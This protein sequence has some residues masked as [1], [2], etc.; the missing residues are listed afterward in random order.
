MV[1]KYECRTNFFFSNKC[2]ST[3]MLHEEQSTDNKSYKH[4]NETNILI[5]HLIWYMWAWSSCLSNLYEFPTTWW[6]SITVI[7]W[8]ST[9]VPS[10]THIRPVRWL[11]WRREIYNISTWT[12]DPTGRRVAWR[13]IDWYQ[14]RREFAGITVVTIGVAAI[15]RRGMPLLSLRWTDHRWCVMWRMLRVKEGSWMRR[16]GK[17]LVVG[18]IRKT[19]QMQGTLRHILHTAQSRRR[20][21]CT[22]WPAMMKLAQVWVH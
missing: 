19:H 4:G 9:T 13:S 16:R 22:R 2:I 8:S 18:R 6:W 10:V 15:V 21:V 14:W 12:V 1:C 3:S 5:T 11:W 7:S 17:H 20:V